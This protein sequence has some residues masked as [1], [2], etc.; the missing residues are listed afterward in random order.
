MRLRLT[1]R[2]R[3]HIDQRGARFIQQVALSQHRYAG[4]SAQLAQGVQR[5]FGFDPF[6]YHGHS[7][8]SGAFLAITVN[9]F[10]LALTQRYMVLAPVPVKVWWMILPSCAAL[11]GF[12]MLSHLSKE[13]LRY[14][15]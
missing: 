15:Y 9:A 5:R 10:A 11:Y 14:A 7:G 2:L 13:L 6:E 1:L 8:L 4:G 12:F 3:L